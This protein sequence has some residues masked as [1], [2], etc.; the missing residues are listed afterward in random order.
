[1][2]KILSESQ[3]ADALDAHRL[4]TAADTCQ[5]LAFKKGETVF[6]R[7]SDHKGCIYV[8][9][10]TDLKGATA[11]YEPNSIIELPQLL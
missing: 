7:G 10:N 11:T 6:K 3:L 1:M 9:L 5:F 2:W 8:L 4:K